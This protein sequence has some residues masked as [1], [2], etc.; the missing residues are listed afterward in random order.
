[1]IRRDKNIILLW[2]HFLVLLGFLPLS[3]TWAQDNRKILVEDLTGSWCGFCPDGAASMAQLET[4]YPNAIC[5][6]VHISDPMQTTTSDAIGDAYSGGGVNVLMLDRQRFEGENFVQ[7][8]SAYPDLA[9][10]FEERVAMPVEVR[11]S[12][13][14]IALDST[15]RQLTADVRVVFVEKPINYD[16]LRI[17]L[18]LTEDSVVRTQNSYN[19]VN[20]FN[21]YTGHPYFNAGN[22]IQGFV[23]RHVLRADVG[24][25]WGLEGSLPP[26]DSIE[27]E[28]LFVQTYTLELNPEWN[29][30]RLHLIGFV[31]AYNN[32]EQ[33]RPILNAESIDLFSALQTP[34]IPDTLDTDT[35]GVVL[36]LAPFEDIRPILAAYPNPILSGEH[37][38]VAFYAPTNL[39]MQLLLFDIQ[40]KQ[41]AS[42]LS[43]QK[44]SQ[45]WHTL[46]CVLPDLV[47]GQ[48]LLRAATPTHI[49]GLLLDIEGR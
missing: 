24:G 3:K 6:G 42:I 47:S 25:A 31:Q 21:A 15:T 10:R 12:L 45:G 37:L 46:N 35:S 1:M 17:N 41:V 8:T 44:Y 16:A 34:Q 38:N 18:W 5:V 2:A 22:P 49:R 9:Q 13:D 23:H 4:N 29:I 27:A 14:H 26:I 20:F 32:D 28:Q 36:S 48:Y 30:E 19:Q 33:L 11:V 7:L 39:P 43:E 40:G